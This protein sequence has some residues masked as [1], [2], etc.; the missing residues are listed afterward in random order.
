[1][2]NFS[3]ETILPFFHSLLNRVNSERKE[4]A[5]A[6]VYSFNREFQPLGSTETRSQ[7]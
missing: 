5:P 3:G 2:G 7:N 4:C 6:G 1:M